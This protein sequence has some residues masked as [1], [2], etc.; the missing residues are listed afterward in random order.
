LLVEIALPSEHAPAA[1]AGLVAYCRGDDA[2]LGRCRDALTKASGHPEAKALLVTLAARRLE[3]IVALR[4]SDV[5]NPALIVEQANLLRETDAGAAARALSEIVEFTP[6]DFAARQRYARELKRLGR[7]AESCAQLAAAVQL[8]P[9]QR[10]TFRDMMRM[11]RDNAD[12]AKAIRACIVDGVSKLPVQRAVS[13]V[14]T[15]EDPSADVDLH[16]HEPGGQHVFY[17][18]RESANGGFLYYDITDGFGPEIYTLGQAV[19]GEYQLAIVYYSGSQP[20]LSGT[21]TVLRNAGSPEETREERPFVLKQ[22]DSSVE[23]PVGTLVL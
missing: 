10:D 15:W 5:A 8:N 6:H 12:H 19:K 21:L 18:A 20:N 23:V 22:A 1:V 7:V 9:G 13:L 3:Q 17:Q 4:R 16:I 2:E 14:M 11:R